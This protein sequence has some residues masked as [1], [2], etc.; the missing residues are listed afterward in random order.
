MAG[1]DTDSFQ[2]FEHA[3]SLGRLGGQVASMVGYRT[4]GQV[5]SLHRGLPS[6]YLTF[7]V[8]LDGPI[9]TGSTSRARDEGTANAHELILGGLHPRP[10][11]IFQPEHQ[12]GVQMSVHPLAARALFGASTAELTGLAY[13]ASDVLGDG[14]WRMQDQLAEL[15]SWR[16]RF[17]VM[18]RYL[19]DRVSAAPSNAPPRPEVVRAWRWMIEQRGAGRMDEL[20]AQVAMSSRQLAKLFNAEVGMPPKMINRLIRFDVTRQQVQ[21]RARSGGPLGLTEIAHERGYYDHAHLVRDFREFAGVS[22]T[23]WLVEE[24]GNIQAGGHRN[25]EDLVA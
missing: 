21:R 4:E 25:G 16:G 13:D 14:A 12:V 3:S 9:I 24:F 2:A 5:P 1:D 10:A 11:Y 7:I 20:S 15:D 19:L 17:E 8:S 6:P 23:G 22:P 18:R